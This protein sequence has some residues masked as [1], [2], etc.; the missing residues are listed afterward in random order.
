MQSD[1]RMQECLLTRE[2]VVSP[3]P[4]KIAVPLPIPAGMSCPC[5]ALQALQALRAPIKRRAPPA[6]NTKHTGRQHRNAVWPI[7]SVES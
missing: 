4:I 5:G 1:P 3:P 6:E 7:A 2:V